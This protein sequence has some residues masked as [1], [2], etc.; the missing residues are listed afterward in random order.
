MFAAE[1]IIG[2]G[3]APC[4]TSCLEKDHGMRKPGPKSLGRDEVIIGRGI[5][6]FY[7]ITGGR[8]PKAKGIQ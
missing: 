7:R 2:R 3:P 8:P 5:D 6:T 1:E 4:P